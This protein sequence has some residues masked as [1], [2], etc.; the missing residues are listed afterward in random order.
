M[1]PIQ[2]DRGLT[3]A[4]ATRRRIARQTRP[5]GSARDAVER[6]LKG[7]EPHP[8][9]AIDRHWKLVSDHRAAPPLLEGA[10]AELLRPPVGVMRR[11]WQ[12]GVGGDAVRA[13]LADELRAYAAPADAATA[14]ALRQ[15]P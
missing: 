10:T 13:A 7:Q 14:A 12:V 15:A 9:L 5:A 6:L 1:N 8:A 2:R 11:R 4:R 3:A